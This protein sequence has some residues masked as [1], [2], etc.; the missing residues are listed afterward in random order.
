[1]ILQWSWGDLIGLFVIMCKLCNLL[2]TLN[3]RIM[4]TS[5]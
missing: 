2:S 4:L 5:Q 3:Y 1:M